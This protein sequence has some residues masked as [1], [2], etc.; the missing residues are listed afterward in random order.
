MTLPN[1]MERI[2][3][4]AVL[5]TPGDRAEVLLAALFAHASSGCPPPRASC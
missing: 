4:G 3:D 2:T 5:I 1:L